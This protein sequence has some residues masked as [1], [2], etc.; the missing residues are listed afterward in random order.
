MSIYLAS[1]SPRRRQL[2]NQIDIEF[3]SLVV[4]I[5]ETPYQQEVPQQYVERMAVEKVKA[6]WDNPQRKE[7]IPVLAADTN[8]ILNGQILGKPIST[9]DATSMLKKLSDKTHQVITSVAVSNGKN[10]EF[11]TNTTNVTFCKLPIELNEYYVS[12]GDCMDKAGAYGIQSF[13]AR[14]VKQLS[15]SY[16]GVVGLPLYETAQLLQKFR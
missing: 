8:V 1:K 7:I 13:A 16:S 5:D 10:I 2:L 3:I 14:F 15:G 9:E 4:E 11:V 12:T 6:G